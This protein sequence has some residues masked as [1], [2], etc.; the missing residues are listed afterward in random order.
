MQLPVP[1]HAGSRI[2]AKLTNADKYENCPTDTADYYDL[3][4]SLKQILKKRCQVNHKRECI[5]F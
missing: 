2:Q 3:W 5:T 4:I 1:P